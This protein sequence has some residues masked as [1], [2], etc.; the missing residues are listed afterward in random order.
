[1]IEIEL[2]KFNE[3]ADPCLEITACNMELSRERK[4]NRREKTSPC[5]LCGKG[6]KTDG[7]GNRNMRF[8]NVSVKHENCLIQIVYTV[9]VE[10]FGKPALCYQ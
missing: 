3:N 9:A 1:M 6:D 5:A 2:Y 10:C 4:T 8:Q 7:N